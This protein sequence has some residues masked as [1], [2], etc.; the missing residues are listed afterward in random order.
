MGNLRLRK[1]C[2]LHEV[3]EHMSGRTGTPESQAL[4]FCAMCITLASSLVSES[5]LVRMLPPPLCLLSARLLDLRSGT[6]GL[7]LLVVL[8]VLQ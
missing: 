6:A 2:D 7:L 8:G 5:L 1:E 4:A 3:M